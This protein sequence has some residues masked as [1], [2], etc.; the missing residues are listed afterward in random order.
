MR[1]GV[2]LSIARSRHVAPEASDASETETGG[3]RDAMHGGARFSS[4]GDADGILPMQA[5]GGT[6]KSAERQ[7]L[8]GLRGE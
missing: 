5:S 4:T 2:C 6:G 1:A 3:M 8:M 7:N